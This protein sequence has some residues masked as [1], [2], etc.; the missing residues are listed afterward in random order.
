MCLGRWVGAWGTKFAKAKTGWARP[1]S[2]MWEIQQNGLV[3]G[4]VN[5]GSTYVFINKVLLEYQHAHLFTI[6]YAAFC[7]IMAK[8]SSNREFMV[9]KI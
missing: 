5:Y 3:Q 6:T 2:E 1:L 8:F 9:Y 4:S 7:I